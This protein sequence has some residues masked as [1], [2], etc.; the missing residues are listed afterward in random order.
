MAKHGSFKLPNFVTSASNGTSDAVWSKQLCESL[1][2]P[3]HWA[4]NGLPLL[5]GKSSFSQSNK[6]DVTDTPVPS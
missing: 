6:Q 3:H 1:C 2:S 5:S 4:V